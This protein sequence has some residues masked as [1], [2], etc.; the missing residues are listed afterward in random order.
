MPEGSVLDKQTKNLGSLPAGC[1]SIAYQRPRLVWSGIRRDKQGGIRGPRKTLTMKQ[2]DAPI[3]TSVFAQKKSFGVISFG[4]HAAFRAVDRQVGGLRFQSHGTGLSFFFLR[5][6][7][8]PVY[9]S[10]TCSC[11]ELGRQE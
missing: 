11:H 3:P 10:R 7:F 4:K 6:T 9:G 2:R 1:H 8:L 5:T